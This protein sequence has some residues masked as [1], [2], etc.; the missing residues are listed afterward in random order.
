MLRSVLTLERIIE[1]AR[2]AFSTCVCFI[3]RRQ[4]AM[5][6]VVESLLYL[7]CL[8]RMPSLRTQSYIFCVVV[9]LAGSV[10]V[11]SANRTFMA[12]SFVLFTEGTR[13]VSFQAHGTQIISTV[14][15]ASG[16]LRAQ[17]A[18]FGTVCFGSLVTGKQECRQP[19][20]GLLGGSLAPWCANGG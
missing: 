6:A 19:W 13:A 1:T 3:S 16:F 15:L 14:R 18:L 4:I 7:F 20:K 17:G 2:L 8:R 9:L 12:V 11:M 5:N 10:Q